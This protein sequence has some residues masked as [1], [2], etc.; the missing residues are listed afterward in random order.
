[1]LMFSSKYSFS[2]CYKILSISY[3]PSYIL[4]C[5]GFNDTA[6]LKTFFEFWRN[7]GRKKR[8][9]QFMIHM[10]N[11]WKEPIQTIQT[12]TKKKLKWKIW[13]RRCLQWCRTYCKRQTSSYSRS[14][15]FVYHQQPKIIQINLLLRLY[16]LF[17]IYPFLFRVKYE[18]KKYT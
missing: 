1:M 11:S 2:Y 6:I 15:N 3:R 10:M 7:C 18:R 17:Y 16:V 9:E 8:K 12:S 4:F 5:S 14:S 13:R